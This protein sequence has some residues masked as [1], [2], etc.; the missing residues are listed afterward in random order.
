[1]L[2]VQSQFPMA[3]L[4]GLFLAS[5]GATLIAGGMVPGFRQRSIWA[6][7]ALGVAAVS[8][9]GGRL[10][11]PPPPTAFQLG[12]LTLALTAEAAAFVLL[13][14]R[15]HRAGERA[16]I[17][18][19]LGIVGAHFLPML[20]AFG[21]AVGALGLLCIANAFLLW[22]VRRYGLA[23]GWTVDGLL[24]LAFGLVMLTGVD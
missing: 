18:G 20:P 5:V 22:R 10:L 15:L 6:G 19:T 23:M 16:V 12:A 14:P 11:A 4:A 9:L 13:L 24:K 2:D 7:L 3:P 21:P 17:A 8:L 1:M